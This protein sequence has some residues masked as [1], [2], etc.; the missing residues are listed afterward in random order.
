VHWEAAHALEA[1]VAT[2]LPGLSLARIDGKSP[3][4][5]LAEP[6]REAV[7]RASMA[8]LQAPPPSLASIASRWAQAF[9]A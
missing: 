7:R 2:L 4:E 8:L 1:R 9:T 5:Y 6:Q 3:V